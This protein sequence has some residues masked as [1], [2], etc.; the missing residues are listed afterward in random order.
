MYQRSADAHNK[1]QWHDFNPYYF[2]WN[3]NHK[4]NLLN[5]IIFARKNNPVIHTC[6][7]LILNFWN[8]QKYIPHYFFFQI[9]FDTLITDRL[10]QYQC[11]IIDDTQ[12]HLLVAVLEQPYNKADYIKIVSQASIHKMSYVKDSKSGSYYDYLLNNT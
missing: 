11:S 3:N 9:M 6:L 5:S 4:V 8:T 12:P 1:Q 7:D 2:S 10:S